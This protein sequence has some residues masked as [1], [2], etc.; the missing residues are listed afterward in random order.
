MNFI[1]LR[2][3]LF[4]CKQDANKNYTSQLNKLLILAKNIRIVER[5]FY[6]STDWEKVMFNTANY[7]YLKVDFKK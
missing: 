6:H 5:E 3:S 1:A 4:Y 2:Y 7:S